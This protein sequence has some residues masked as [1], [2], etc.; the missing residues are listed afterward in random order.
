MSV[1]KVFLYIVGAVT[2]ASVVI[3]AIAVFAYLAY[4]FLVA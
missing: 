4:T 1:S 3:T 2:V